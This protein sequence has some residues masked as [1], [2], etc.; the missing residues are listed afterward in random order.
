MYIMNLNTNTIINEI[1]NTSAS[2]TTNFIGLS[3]DESNHIPSMSDE[4]TIEYK[5]WLAGEDS[6]TMVDWHT[7]TSSTTQE[8]YAALV[9]NK[10]SYPFLLDTGATIHISLI[11]TDFEFL[12]PTSSWTI[13]GVGGSSIS[14]S[15]IGNIKL[16]IMKKTHIVLKDVPQ[17]AV[18]LISISCMSNDSQIT[19][20][21]NNQIC[22]LT[23][24]MSNTIIAQGTLT[25]QN[26]Y[27]L[28]LFKSQTDNALITTA[29]PNI[30]TWHRRLG[31]TN[32][33]A[34]SDMSHKD[35]V[36]GMSFDPSIVPSKCQS[37]VT[38]K[39][40]WTPVPKA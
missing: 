10:G 37:C 1:L 7:C 32:Y 38:G 9:I 26:L 14:A 8:E 12:K 3:S 19:L 31:H 16:Q 4:D 22:W 27:A 35:M 6:N 36:T 13:R 15:G 23:D 40:T 20:H 11:S 34:V 17:V 25:S 30:E 28:N 21:F 5:G 2:D 24:K 33:Q 29:Q 18:C 39:Q